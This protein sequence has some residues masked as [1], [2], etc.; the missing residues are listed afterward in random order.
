MS[1][2]E[3][4]AKILL[5][6]KSI[7]NDPSFNLDQFKQYLNTKEHQITP[8]I[9]Q[10]NEA[11]ESALSI[12]TESNHFKINNLIEQPKSERGLV[13]GVF[14]MAHFGH[15]NAFRQATKLCDQLVVAVNGD[16][17]VTKAKGFNY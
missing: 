11:K 13:E 8:T 6:M 16:E 9:I 3:I 14:D 7:L 17:E 5:T 15:F 10:T 2:I 1:K 4:E 12:L